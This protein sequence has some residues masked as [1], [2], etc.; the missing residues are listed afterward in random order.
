[1]KP[2]HASTRSR[3]ER[4]EQLD[5]ASPSGI[6]H[7][8]LIKHSAGWADDRCE[9]WL[10][11]NGYRVTT[12]VSND[13][14]TLP[15]IEGFSHVIVYGGEPC[16]KD[17]DHMPSLRM[18]MRYLETVLSNNMPCLG[19]CLGAQLIAHVLG[20]DIKPL[21]CGTEEFGCSMITPTEAGNDFMPHPCNMLQWHCE[22]FGLPDDCTLL[23]T[24]ELFPNQ[25]F[26]YGKHTFGVQFHPEVTSDVLQLWHQRY[27][28]NAS[29]V[30][31][32]RQ[33][34]RQL[35]DC[36]LYTRQNEQW[37]NQFM[38]HWTETTK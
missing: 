15:G 17:A 12:H 8:L 24:G 13:G 5:T 32:A 34:A 22:G 9:S 36:H 29:S 7:C 30:P 11:S 37:F 1:M 31:V 6:K 27:L 25:A 33:C 38:Q 19:I 4:A 18:E 14:N 16:V 26:R 21:P 23:A 20:A 28:A 35:K 3:V 2:L 10:R